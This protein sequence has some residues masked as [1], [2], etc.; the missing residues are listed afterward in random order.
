MSANDN[1]LGPAWNQSR[2]FLTDDWFPEYSAAKYIPYGAIGAEPHL[3][4]L[5]LWK[6]KVN[7]KT[8][9][10]LKSFAFSQIYEYQKES[11]HHEFELYDG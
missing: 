9:M 3:L 8:L 4:Q 5:K 10:S 6:G 7:P 1:G 11:Y 2:Y